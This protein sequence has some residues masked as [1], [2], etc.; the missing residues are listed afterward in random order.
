MIF[1]S[2]LLTYVESYAD[3]IP[4]HQHRERIFNAMHSAIDGLPPYSLDAEA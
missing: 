3:Q 1:S 2:I 4:S